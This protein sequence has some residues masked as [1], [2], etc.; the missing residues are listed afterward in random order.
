[1]QDSYIFCIYSCKKNSKKAEALYQMFGTVL[2]ERANMKVL[3]VYGDPLIQKNYILNNKYMVLKVPDDYH[4]LHYKTLEMFKMIYTLFPKCKGCFKCDDDMVLNIP[5]ILSFLAVMKEMD[6]PYCGK[7]C[8]LTAKK[9]NID[10][11]QQKGII[12]ISIINTPAAVYCCGPLYYI[13]NKSLKVIQNTDEKEIEEIFYE[14]LMIGYLLNKYHIYPINNNLCSDISLHFNYQFSFHNS[15][16]K[17]TLMVVL[18]DDIGEQ[19][20]QTANAYTLSKDLD[21]HL[22]LLYKNTETQ[23]SIFSFL[24]SI[25]RSCIDEKSIPLLKKGVSPVPDDD[26]LIIDIE[27]DDIIP[28]QDPS[29]DKYKKELQNV[30]KQN[31]EYKN[32]VNSFKNKDNYFIHLCNTKNTPSS[33][34]YINAIEQILSTDPSASFYIFTDDISFCKTFSLI[35][36]H[37]NIQFIE[38]P[39]SI[40]SLYLMSLCEKGGIVSNDSISWWGAYLNSNEKKRVFYPPK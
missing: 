15:K 34:Y 6:L 33:I 8:I 27:D 12:P 7:V 4:H 35:Q 2:E 9:N 31:N 23:L 36:T 40:S 20:F 38:D 29:F 21:C 3:I 13:N 25:F 37:K 14:D 16:H 28:K 39:K 18:Q 19:L 1:M 11:L 24:P 17:K 32:V 10:H 26:F 5:S 30:M 22:F